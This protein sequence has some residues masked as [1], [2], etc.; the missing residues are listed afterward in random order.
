[1]HSFRVLV[2]LLIFMPDVQSHERTPTNINTVE[3]FVAAFNAHDSNAMANFVADDIE[4]LSIAGKQVGLEAKGKDNLIASMDSYF[5]SCPTCRSELAEVLA[6]TSRVSAIEI[7][8]WQGTSGRKSQRA[9]SVY[10]FSNGVITRV[11][12]FPAEK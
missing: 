4:W 3:R 12:Y 11:Y 5:K 8:S 6:T 1:M 9:I 7:A 2:L 10:E